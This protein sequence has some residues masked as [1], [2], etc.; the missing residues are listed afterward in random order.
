LVP[1]DARGGAR[2][3]CDAEILCPGRE[4]GGPPE[5]SRGA[6]LE[7]FDAAPSLFKDTYWKLH[8]AGHR[9]RTLFVVSDERSIPWE[10]VIP[11][12]RMASGKRELHEPLGTELAV[13]RWHRQIGVSPRQRIPLRTSYVM[14]PEY[15]ASARLAFAAVESEF[16]FSHS[17]DAGSTR[18]GSEGG[19][20]RGRDGV[21]LVAVVPRE[22]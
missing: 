17:R 22:A 11:H 20:L 3:G 1:A 9:P 15:S 8:D 16:V 13:G 18:R 14:A 4:P 21:F 7:L 5:L 12:R 19:W 2:R 10:L 6:G